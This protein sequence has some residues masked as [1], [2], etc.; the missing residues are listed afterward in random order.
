MTL[1]L[2][3]LN[4]TESSLTYSKFLAIYDFEIL[5]LKIKI[6]ENFC[7]NL[8][9]RLN[10]LRRY[11]ARGASCVIGDVPDFYV[12]DGFLIDA[13]ISVTHWLSS[14]VS[15]DWFNEKTCRV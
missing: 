6:F 1:D 7:Q 15:F 4:F 5:S 12:E 9:Q 3:T 2:V 11:Y 14:I 10:F 8:K 13:L